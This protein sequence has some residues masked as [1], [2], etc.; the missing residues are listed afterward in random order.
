MAT[1]NQKPV[2]NGNASELPPDSELFAAPVGGNAEALSEREAFAGDENFYKAMADSVPPAADQTPAG[3]PPGTDAAPPQPAQA[4]V[5]GKR[6]SAL[7]KILIISIVII[8]AMLLFGLLQL[9][10][11]QPNTCQMPKF[12]IPQPASAG[13]SVDEQAQQPILP[14]QRK[15]M[16]MKEADA[17]FLRGDYNNACA[18]YVQLRQA[19][20]ADAKSE[21]LK[22]FFSLKIALCMKEA[23]NTEQAEELFKAVLNSRSPF[24]RLLANYNTAL[25]ESAKKQYLRAQS[26]AYQALA[27]AGAVDSGKDWALLL[28]R[29]CQFL[30]AECMTRN[31]LS[32]RDAD[33]E[34][35]DAL[36]VRPAALP[37]IVAEANVDE[38]QLRSFLDS[39]E[40]YLLK[41][42]LTPVVQKLDQQQRNL[43]HWMV[44]CNGASIEELLARF[45]ANA[46]L[47]V[48]WGSGAEDIK[49]AVR[50]RPVILYMPAATLQQFVGTASGSAGL[51]AYIDDRSDKPAINVYNPA[52]Y[53]ALS[54]HISLLS[55]QAISL[56]QIFS[57]MFPDDKCIPNAHFS[58]A[59]LQAQQGK[60]TESIAECKLVANRFSQSTLAPFALLQSSRLKTDLCDY[61]GAKE[62]LQQLV[63]QYPNT[64]VSGKA[65]LYL[66][67]T[68]MKTQLYN[69]AE[70][71]YRKVYAMGFSRESQAAAALGAGRC[72]YE[73]KDYENA[74]KWLTRYIGLAGDQAD[75]DLYPAYILLGKVFLDLGKHQQ[76][77]EAF[78]GALKGHLSKEQGVE[79]ISALAETEMQR[80]NMVEALNALENINYWQLSQ[81]E[82]TA[83]L[84]LKSKILRCMG[85]A[86]NATAELSDKTEYIT[87]PQLRAAVSL[88]LTRCYIAKGDL[89]S[90]RRNLAENLVTVAAGP[91]A[92][93]IAL[94]L[95]QVC[96]R[97]GQD[98]QAVSVCRQLL[99][100]TSEPQ[101][102]RK[103][104]DLLAQAY[105]RQKNYDKAAEALTGRWNGTDEKTQRKVSTA[106]A[107]PSAAAR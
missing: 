35:P 94:D 38:E 11:P 31:I 104:L 72:F 67:D 46:G 53:S 68:T 48:R 100:M 12:V 36:W 80:G 13:P 89:E 86:D 77:I 8:A 56:W 44:V 5:G 73:K 16:S 28:Q 98:S 19:L 3:A 26:R 64:D 59:L 15:P 83:V 1:E 2:N 70:R 55:Q 21:M 10:L 88:E 22:D 37:G 74:S 45:A 50:R 18:A 25:L 9:L 30:I 92:Q 78:Q 90:A 29:N 71:L 106:T 87:D 102:K 51:L 7:R 57:L 42:L 20:P 61:A 69:E 99:D 39:G 95:A 17:Y 4:A 105:K 85:L 60:V 41:G 82:S 66:A 43:S 101:V 27:L 96:L 49:D 91:L 65:C 14:E 79:A 33:R 75:K 103:A 81:K 62:D 58:I 97:L 93:E 84:L 24:V 34:L 40:Q 32:L 47:D 76:A 52:D 23:G 6:F 107:A 63:E 54:E